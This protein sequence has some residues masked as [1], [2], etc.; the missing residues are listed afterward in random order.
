MKES[1]GNLSNPYK[2]KANENVQENPYAAAYAKEE[3][4]EDSQKYVKKHKTAIRVA[5]TIVAGLPGLG[6]SY[7]MTKDK[8]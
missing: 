8:K 2:A 3:T 1:K 6:I 4:K 7:L 5:S